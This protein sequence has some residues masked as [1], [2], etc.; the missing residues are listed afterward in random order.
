MPPTKDKD[1]LIEEK[2]IGLITKAKELG[3]VKQ[4]KHP[5][6]GE[7]VL[8]VGEEPK[9]DEWE[10]LE[11]FANNRR[12][13]NLK[14]SLSD[15]A[16]TSSN[17]EIKLFKE[18]I[19]DYQDRYKALIKT[20]NKQDDEIE[21]LKGNLDYSSK[22]IKKFGDDLLYFQK[23]K[24]NVRYEL[25]LKQYRDEIK[26]LKHQLQTQRDDIFKDFRKKLHKESEFLHPDF[27]NKLF[28]EKEDLRELKQKHNKEQ[29]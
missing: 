7:K 13:I 21:E 12:K 11:D 23:K 26:E 4:I 28:I 14:L 2:R 20:S 22:R 15:K 6:T 16:L 29:D 8:L 18:T 27:K 1:K 24:A 25:K 10:E 9:T 3:L 17:K 5:A 19:K